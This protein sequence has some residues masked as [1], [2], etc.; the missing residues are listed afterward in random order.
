MCNAL[1][2]TTVFLARAGLP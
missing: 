1:C 2:L